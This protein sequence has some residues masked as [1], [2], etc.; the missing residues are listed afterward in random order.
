MRADLD[1]FVL[2]HGRKT[3]MPDVLSGWLE[4]LFPGERSKQEAWLDKVTHIK[5]KTRLTMRPPAPLAAVPPDGP[6][7]A[8]IEGEQAEAEVEPPAE[9]ARAPALAATLQSAESPLQPRPAPEIATPEPAPAAEPPVEVAPAPVPKRDSPPPPPP[10]PV[11]AAPKPPAK[12]APPAKELAPVAEAQPPAETAPPR[13]MGRAIV[14]LL[15]TAAA[16][17]AIAW[18]LGILRF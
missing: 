11:E 18:Y 13:S 9:A 15:L 7:V 16:L 5:T 17:A 8:I 1:A 14:A 12:K 4:E 2:K 3:P 6:S 10:A